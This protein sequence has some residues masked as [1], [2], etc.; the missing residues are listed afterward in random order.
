ME[1]GNVLAV[2][3]TIIVVLFMFLLA[4]LKGLREDIIDLE[5]RIAQKVLKPDC[6][7]EMDM[8]RCDLREVVKDVKDILKGERY[9]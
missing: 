8:V 2:I 5:I 9:E 1:I 7:R 6:A 4:M 3:G